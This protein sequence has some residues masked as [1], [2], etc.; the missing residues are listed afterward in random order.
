MAALI[1]MD[2]W[3]NMNLKSVSAAPVDKLPA[4]VLMIIGAYLV[5]APVWYPGLA[6]RLFDDARYVQLAFLVPILALMCCGPLNT[7]VVEVWEDLSRRTRALLITLFM[8][9]FVSAVVS[10]KPELGALELALMMQIVLLILLVAA[11]VRQIGDHAQPLLALAVT[12]GALLCVL[13]FA[14]QF[15]SF[16]IERKSFPW[17][18]PFL[19]FSNVRFFSQY[20]AYTLLLM[21]LPTLLFELRKG[22]R[23]MVL[24]LSS[25]FWAMHWMVGTRAAWVG[26]FVALIA[27]MAMSG[28]QRFGW[29]KLQTVPIFAG[30]AI[31]LIFSLLVQ[32]LPRAVTVPGVR[33]IVERDQ[34]SINERLEL[35][36][37]A[38]N[39]IYM[40]PFTGVGPG[41]FGLQSYELNPAHPHNVPLQLLSEYGIPAGMAAI[42]LGFILWGFALKCLQSKTPSQKMIDASLAGALTMGLTDAM[43]SG[44]LIMPHAQMVFCVLTGWILGRNLGTRVLAV[45]SA[46][47]SGKGQFLLVAVT[48][49]AVGVTS[50]LAIEYLPLARE[51]PYQ[52]ERWNPHFWQYGHFSDW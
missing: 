36:R 2:R 5:L 16:A 13:K 21:V 38:V 20:Q 39:G 17:I 23:L 52:F 4:T 47:A 29:L 46:D 48:L 30:G 49:T 45:S 14:V 6:P 10:N 7:V 1:S 18:S 50:V 51:I 19:D 32:H 34:G 9:G 25:C 43:F 27:V 40:R 15:T 44:N 37:I 42:A 3:Q 31:F 22:M 26:L 11:L 33:S 12:A 41:Q 24:A 35:A 28:R 8:A